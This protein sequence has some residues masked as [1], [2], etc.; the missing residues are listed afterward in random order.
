M[1]LPY[2]RRVWKSKKRQRPICF[3]RCRAG[4]RPG[5]IGW[6]LVP[7]AG[8]LIDAW[9]LTR[10]EPQAITLGLIWLALGFGVLTWLTKG[11]RAAPPALHLEDH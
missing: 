9:L 11:F 8:A 6:F 7:L 1:A 10:L 4:A 3:L 2:Y 5:V